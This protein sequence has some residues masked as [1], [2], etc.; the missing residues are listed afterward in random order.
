MN[1]ERG[2][3]L[4]RW[5]RARLR[6]AL[7]GPRAARPEGDWGE[8]R[9][10][11]FVTL[12]RPG[13]SLQGCIG[14]LQAVRGLVD[15]VAHNAVAAGLDDPRGTPLRLAD[16]DGLQV[17]VSVLSPLAPVEFAGGEA[18][19]RAALRP[20]TDGVVLGWRG[21]RATLLPIMWEQLPEAGAF[22]AALKTKAG[23]PRDFWSDE[24]ALWRYGAERFADEGAP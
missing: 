12:R 13:G 18:G 16:V 21:R 5:A 7:G 9:T 1:A 10:A 4:V 2:R 14:S 22:L 3:I 8:A 20:G 15:D 23:L 17:E 11:T 6:E 19:A 24:V